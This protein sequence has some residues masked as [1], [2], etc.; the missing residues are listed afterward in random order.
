LQWE[1]GRIVKD[2]ALEAFVAAIEDH[3]SRHRRREFVLSPPDFALARRWHETKLP[4]AAVLS[5]IDA[6]ISRGDDVTTLRYCRRDVEAVAG[7]G[8]AVRSS[9]GTR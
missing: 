2:P 6:A 1:R 9:D 7:R 5:G 8:R 3:M 4:L